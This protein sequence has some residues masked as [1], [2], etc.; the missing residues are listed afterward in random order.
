MG[1]LQRPAQPGGFSEPG[2]ATKARAVNIGEEDFT[3]ISNYRQR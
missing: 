3:L 2:M 1:A